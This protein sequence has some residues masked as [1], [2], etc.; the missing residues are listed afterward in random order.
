M[1]K[2]AALG[3]SLT[4]GVVL[5]DKNRYSLLEHSFIDII[6]N[7]LDLYIENYGKFGST[8]CGAVPSTIATRPFSVERITPSSDSLS[9]EQRISSQLS[10]LSESSSAIFFIKVLFPV[11]GPPLRI[12][13]RL[14]SSSAK[15]SLKYDLKPQYPFADAKY[16]SVTYT[17]PFSCFDTNNLFL[18]FY[19]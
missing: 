14:K 16:F 3:D 8:V 17:T 4:K 6:S 12:K 18:S 1:I 5:T 7:E 15:I 9:D 11:P 2:I 19:F 10:T 13:N